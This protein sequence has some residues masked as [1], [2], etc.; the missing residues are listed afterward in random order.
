[1]GSCLSINTE[2]PP[3]DDGLPVPVNLDALGL[4]LPSLRSL[5]IGGASI[6]Y[7]GG[8]S[9][10]RNLEDLLL[11]PPIFCSAPLA[12]LDVEEP[13]GPATAHLLSSI[14][15]SSVLKRLKFGYGDSYSPLWFPLLRRFPLLEELW[16]VSWSGQ[17]LGITPLMEVANACSEADPDDEEKLVCR[18]RRV[19]AIVGERVSL[20]QTE[21]ETALELLNCASEVT[22][23]RDLSAAWVVLGN[24]EAHVAELDLEAL[25]R[26]LPAGCRLAIV[27]I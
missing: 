10:Y 18:L 8:L 15:V 26:K 12:T 17:E 23:R 5:S 22:I 25:S 6:L 24:Y 21:L 19:T 14:G 11:A 2:N 7:T 4:V 27:D 16:N 13:T 9:N 3:G 1:M 20:I